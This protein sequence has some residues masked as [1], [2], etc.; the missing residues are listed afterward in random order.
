[1]TKLK[2][3]CDDHSD[4]YSIISAQKY[5]DEKVNP[6]IR[7]Y[8]S[9]IREYFKKYTDEIKV[10]GG[11][12]VDLKKSFQEFLQKKGSCL[13]DDDELLMGYWMIEFLKVSKDTP[14]DQLDAII[15]P[16]QKLNKPYI[17]QRIRELRW[18]NFIFYIYL[19][20]KNNSDHSSWPIDLLWWPPW[21]RDHALLIRN[22]SLPS[23]TSS[24][25]SMPSTEMASG[26][27]P[28]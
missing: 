13:K 11:S 2:K 3:C 21:T 17:E 5:F 24:L 23:I 9:V 1:M 26:G 20:N 10:V 27:Q 22:P 15:E 8:K 7:K 19:K 14:K 6:S 4:E 25:T 12:K 18:I 28:S 16:K